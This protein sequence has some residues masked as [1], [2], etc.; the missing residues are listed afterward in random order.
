MFVPVA[1][2]KYLNVCDIKRPSDLRSDHTSLL[3][4]Y[5]QTCSAGDA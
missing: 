5:S 3:T 1:R 2:L 4:R